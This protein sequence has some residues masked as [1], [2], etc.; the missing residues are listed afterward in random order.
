MGE[1]DNDEFLG[2]ILRINRLHENRK[3]HISNSFQDY[4]LRA[5]DVNVTEFEGFSE[6]PAQMFT[7][8]LF[9]AEP[10]EMWT[11]ALERCD[12]HI[13]VG[14]TEL[15]FWR[16][17]M[18]RLQEGRFDDWEL[19]AEVLTISETVWEEGAEVVA[20]EI[21]KIEAKYDLLSRIEAFER[22]SKAQV[23]RLGI[24]GN[25]PPEEINDPTIIREITVI[26]D[27]VNDLKEEVEDEAPTKAK[28][29]KLVAL[30]SAG[31]KSIFHL[32]GRLGEHALK[33]GVTLTVTAGGAKVF[34]PELLEA[35]IEAAKRFLSSGAAG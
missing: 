18:V 20:A 7:A 23:T 3:A 10:S 29:E 27:V 8:P 6:T 16:S 17:V 12:E 32:C 2:S 31:L 35:V 14:R 19:L 4:D 5:R 22:E 13:A 34:K 11:R 24:G 21:E 33:V 30:L 25:N 1:K 28:I 9:A 15:T 26:W